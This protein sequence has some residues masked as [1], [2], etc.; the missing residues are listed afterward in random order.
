VKTKTRSTRREV[1]QSAVLM[2]VPALTG[3]GEVAAPQSATASLSQTPQPMVST[4]PPVTAAVAMRRYVDAVNRGDTDAVAQCFALDARFD[5]AGAVF[6]GRDDIMRRFLVPDVLIPGGRYEVLA[7]REEP[8]AAIFEFNFRAGSVFE[9]FTYRCV[10][11]DG[12]I[13][14]VVGR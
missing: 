2:M 10:T 14:E 8:N 3:C 4:R 5:R 7:M 11:R 13:Y 1:F 12:L 6:Q 9:H